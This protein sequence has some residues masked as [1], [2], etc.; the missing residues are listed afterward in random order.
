[1]I[2]GVDMAKRK[3]ASF[4][5]ASPLRFAVVKFYQVLDKLIPGNTAVPVAPPLQVHPRLELEQQAFVFA[6]YAV[7]VFTPVSLEAAGFEMEADNLRALPRIDSVDSARAA[8]A[9]LNASAAETETDYAAIGQQLYKERFRQSSPRVDLLDRSQKAAKAAY[10]VALAA[11]RSL[12]YAANGDA[13]LA[14][15]Y[16]ANIAVRAASLNPDTVW[17]AVNEMLADL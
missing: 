10:T 2:E 8:H 17:P 4:T 11:V 16:A 15:Q 5:G 12:D 1:L 9:V 3:N 13:N 14:A 7:R 6:D